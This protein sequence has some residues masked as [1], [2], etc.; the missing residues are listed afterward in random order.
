MRQEYFNQTL[1]D[2]ER[3][4]AWE[5]SGSLDGRG[6]ARRKAREIL[7]AHTPRGIDPRVDQEIRKRFDIRVS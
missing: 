6:R 7:K 4:E 2:R 5:K 3:R 1:G